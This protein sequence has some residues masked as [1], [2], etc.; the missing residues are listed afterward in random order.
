VFPYKFKVKCS[1]CPNDCLGVCANRNKVLIDP[2]A[3][4]NTNTL[5]NRADTCGPGDNLAT[6]LRSVAIDIAD[7]D[8]QG[9]RPLDQPMNELVIY[10]MHVGGFTRH[11]AAGVAHPGTFS[12]VVEKIPYLKELGITAVELLP[13]MEF[14]FPATAGPSG[15]AASATT[16]AV[17]SAA[18]RTA[19]IA[20][21][22]SSPAAP[23][24]YPAGRGRGSTGVGFTR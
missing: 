19:G 22:T 5:W 12:A 21:K 23:R 9:D 7:Y 2:Y 11:P 18:M 10:E 20:K 4:G 17:S 24:G 16:S 3:L 8:W 1:G 13:A 6:S 15:M 14:D